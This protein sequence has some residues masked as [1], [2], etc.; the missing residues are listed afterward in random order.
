MSSITLHLIES[1]EK[2]ARRPRTLNPFELIIREVAVESMKLGDPVRVGPLAARSIRL[3]TALF[4]IYS[5]STSIV[6]VAVAPFNPLL[7]VAMVAASI[8][9]LAVAEAL[10]H[11][12]RSVLANGIEQELPALLLYILPYSSSPRYLADVIRSV[13]TDIFKWTRHEAAKLSLFIDMGNDPIKALQLLAKTTPS[14]GLKKILVEY[15]N[16]QWIGATRV[17]TSLKITE[18]AVESIREKWKS[19]SELGK[20]V[21]EALA[22][23]FVAIAALSPIAGGGES[24]LLLLAPLLAGILASVLLL[25]VRPQ[26]GDLPSPA[27]PAALPLASTIISS[28]LV[29]RGLILPA[30]VLLVAALIPMEVLARRSRGR[31][32]ESL[33]A[34]S[35][36]A[37]HARFGRDYEGLLRKAEAY[38]GG[39][40]KAIARASR[41]AGNLGVA[42]ALERLVDILW[43]AIS[44]RRNAWLE[45][46]VLEILS[47]LAP[48]VGG[49]AMIK[50]N[51]F[52]SATQTPF[53]PAGNNINP[54]LV[55]ASAIAAPLPAAVLRRGR[56]ASVASAL[57]A[58]LAL[59]YLTRTMP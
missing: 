16:L 51:A 1:L 25:V 54:Q 3:A 37:E 43:E 55:M 41:V 11:M 15:T 10:P 9:L 48:V 29:L 2:Y 59:L 8:L 20:L 26:L 35:A 13:P 45:A 21:V 19:Y 27:W 6:A 4:I 33:Q 24:T 22:S 18:R 17:A 53:L 44:I 7:A 34:L 12:W 42:D 36:A 49:L 58:L 38:G 52:F 50:L 32:A 14:K 30:I 31:E 40:I 5:L 47:A 28:I 56:L 23:G 46:I 57:A 39:V